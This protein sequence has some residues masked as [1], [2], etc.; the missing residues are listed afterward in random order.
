MFDI[1]KRVDFLLLHYTLKFPL[2]HF[3]QILKIYLFYFSTEKIH[4]LIIIIK[5][6]RSTSDSKIFQHF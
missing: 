6:R 5:N 3:Y 2:P 1:K 4:S